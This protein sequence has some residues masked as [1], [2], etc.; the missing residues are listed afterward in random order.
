MFAVMFKFDLTE[1]DD[2]PKT[3]NSKSFR[4][5]ATDTNK[6]NVIEEHDGKTYPKSNLVKIKELIL[7]SDLVKIKQVKDLLN[8]VN[9][10]KNFE[11][12]ETSDDS[13]MMKEA[14]KD[15]SP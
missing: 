15:I 13:E 8:K 11:L 1:E 7:K 2:E 6:T 5:T 14:Y 12:E 9:K 3:K 4:F 10:E